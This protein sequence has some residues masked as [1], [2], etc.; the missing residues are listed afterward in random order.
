MKPRLAAATPLLAA[1]FAVSLYGGIAPALAQ[2]PA[3]D[4]RSQY[5]KRDYMAPMRDGVKLFTIVYTPR[6]T[7][8][9]YPVILFRTPYS[10]PPYEPEAY[11][12]RLG[13]SSEFDREGYIFVF[14]DVRGKFRSEGEFEVM[15]PFKRVKRTPK[16]VDESSDTYDTI[17]WVL[18]TI[19][20]H[21][22][23]VGMWGVSYPGWQ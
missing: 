4:V 7:T 11:R 18:K 12:A 20:R 21:N 17:D 16:D 3:F 9:T 23:R 2:Q 14:Q 13:P 22:G 6:D 1:A 5:V 15:R 19:P 8:R 10:I